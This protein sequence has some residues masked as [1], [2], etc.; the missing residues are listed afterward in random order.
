MQSSHEIDQ[1]MQDVAP[2]LD[3][4]APPQNLAGSVAP[5]QVPDV[6]STFGVG[7]QSPPQGGSNLAPQAPQAIPEAGADVQPQG[8]PLTG[9]PTPDGGYKTND[10]K[11]MSFQDMWKDMTN[12]EQTQYVDKLEKTGVDVDAA[13][14]KMQQELGQKPSKDLD[15]N[16]KAMLIMEFG[17]SLMKNSSGAAYGGDIG[18]AA[19]EAGLQTLSSYRNMKAGKEA[20]QQRYLNN[21]MSIVKGRQG[22]HV[23]DAQ[24]QEAISGRKATED[25]RA[26]QSKNADLA[27]H[28]PIGNPTT[29]ADGRMIQRFEDGRTEIVKDPDTG[30]PLKAD[31]RLRTGEAPRDL[32]IEDAISVAQD[33]LDKINAKK[34]VS[35]SD[36][37]RAGRLQEKIDRLSKGKGRQTPDDRV[38]ASDYEHVHAANMRSLSALHPDWDEGKLSQTATTMTESTLNRA[39]GYAGGGN[40]APLTPPVQMLKPGVKTRFK[41]GQVWTLDASG[42]PVQVTQ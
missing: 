16:D 1:Y 17:L 4:L 35:L 15:R 38:T 25:W 7:Q 26:A 14:D 10:G 22:A 20:D 8:Q 40:L 23:Q 21:E 29:T 37:A 6:N 3:R 9:G 41:N 34:D 30:V 2:L 12:D 19:G 5:P 32:Q 42:K 36:K 13:Y 18:G 33:Q 31:M 11:K 24:L 27:A 28:R 39:K